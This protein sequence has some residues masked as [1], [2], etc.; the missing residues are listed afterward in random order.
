MREQGISPS[1]PLTIEAKKFEYFQA[2]LNED[3]VNLVVN[4][5]NGSYKYCIEQNT[6]HEVAKKVP[7]KDTSVAELYAFLLLS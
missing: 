6:V 2:Y 7:Y 3:V 5:T 1:F 4:E